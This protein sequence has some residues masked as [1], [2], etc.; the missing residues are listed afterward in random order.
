MLDRL[1]RAMLLFALL[2]LRPVLG[3]F[4]EHASERNLFR[5]LQLGNPRRG[6]NPRVLVLSS[7]NVSLPLPDLLGRQQPVVLDLLKISALESLLGA[8]VGLVLLPFILCLAT[9]SRVIP[10]AIDALR[11][12]N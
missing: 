10:N 3:G 9:D 12:C 2:L 11:I 8:V 4:C 5:D 6:A 7:P 1:L